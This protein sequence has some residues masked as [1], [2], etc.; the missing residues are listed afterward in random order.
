MPLIAINVT[1]LIF[2]T[3]CLQY[4]DASFYQVARGLVLPFTVLFS[5]LL[6]STRSSGSI[7]LS[8]SIVCFG[9]FLGVS[10][11]HINASAVGTML[12]VF[13]SLTTSVHAIV[14]K[15]SLNV[16]QGSTMDLVYYNNLLSA[17]LLSP[18]VLLSGESTTVLEMIATGGRP[19]QTFITGATITG[20]FGFLICIAGFLSIKV[21][22]PVTHMI[23]SAVRGVIQTFLGKWVF[24]DI[25]TTGRGAGIAFILLGSTLYTYIK[26]REQ[27]QKEQI[28]SHGRESPALSISTTS[29]SI[30]F[31]KYNEKPHG[32]SSAHNSPVLSS[33]STFESISSLDPHSRSSTM[34]LNV[35]VALANSAL[36]SPGSTIPSP[37]T[38]RSLMNRQSS[39]HLTPPDATS[40]DQDRTVI[41]GHNEPQ[42]PHR[43]LS[44]DSRTA[45]TM[46]LMH[47][48]PKK[49]N[50]AN[51]RP[52]RND[53]SNVHG[54]SFSVTDL[55]DV[56][57]GSNRIGKHK[58]E[59]LY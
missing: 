41:D 16:V 6:L 40:L 9:F 12:G 2:N 46:P 57:V 31:N 14:V 25:I 11:H 21:T 42:S 27:R 49:V 28:A 55:Q 13:S 53:N 56:L 47:S 34:S 32:I 17:F 4:V 37:R 15:K 48:T 36:T 26:D 51:G 38:P 7:L 43:R 8:V 54:K 10:S 33:S 18:L 50:A 5:Y 35:N 22:S 45:L 23:S 59:K 58:D 29:S 1:G 52:F 20:V 39:C 24:G 3:Y 30:V 19:L 44:Y